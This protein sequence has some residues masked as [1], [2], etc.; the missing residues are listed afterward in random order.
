MLEVG[1]KVK[2]NNDKEY[3][4]LNAFYINYNRYIFLVSNFN[5][6]DIV[7]A[8]EKIKEDNIVLEEI[9]DND[10]LDYIL[11][12]FALNKDDI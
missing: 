8:I 9:K 6:L 1:E 7:V 4:V 5:P 3:M 10:L 11:T 2:L 12:Q